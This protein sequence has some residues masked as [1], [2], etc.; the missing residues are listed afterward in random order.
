MELHKHPV[1]NLLKRPVQSVKMKTF[2]FGY[3]DLV[4]SPFSVSV[5]FHNWPLT[6]KGGDERGLLRVLS[7]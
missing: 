6:M 1:K 2:V 5:N 4:R 3:N 7:L